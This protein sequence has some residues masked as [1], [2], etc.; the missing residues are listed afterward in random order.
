MSAELAAGAAGGQ[1]PLGER[2]LVIVPAAAVFGGLRLPRSRQ[3]DRDCANP[4]YEGVYR[5]F[6]TLL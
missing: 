1:I 5:H 4:P 6:G 3:R 2:M